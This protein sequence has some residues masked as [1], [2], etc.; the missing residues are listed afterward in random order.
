VAL[1]K[2]ATTYQ[3]LEFI[4]RRTALLKKIQRLREMQNILMPGLRDQLTQEQ[5]E[6]FGVDSRGEPK[7]IKLY[8]P[9]G[10]VSAHM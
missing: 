4:K 3:A 1:K 7:T 9:S 5:L 10:I 6:A 2:A 8:L